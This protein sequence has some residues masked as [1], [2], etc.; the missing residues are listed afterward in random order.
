MLC[1][2]ELT[3][4]VRSL[5][6]LTLSAGTDFDIVTFS[7]DP[8]ETADVAAAKKA[9]YLK[10]YGRKDAE[11]GWHFLTGDAASIHAL[12]EAVGFNATRDE[13]TGQ[14]AH[15]AAIMICTPDGRVSRYLYG[16]E[17][18]PR[19]L[20]LALVEASN[21]QTGTVTDRVLLFCY[22]YDPTHGKYGVAILNVVRG[23]GVLTVLVLGTSIAVMLRR[24]RR[25][26]RRELTR[27]VSEGGRSQGL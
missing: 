7:I 23:G 8:A 24:E 18:A 4:L 19:D 13:Q 6:T 5:R 2:L 11:G 22:Q 16:V 1:G 26:R 9:T 21:G 20:R 14:F 10:R 25:T 3:G 27:S 12:C 15:A 17:F